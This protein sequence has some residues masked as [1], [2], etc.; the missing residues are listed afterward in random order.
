[1]NFMAY[2]LYL[3]HKKIIY[4]C[5]HTY[6][7]IHTYVYIRMHAYI[8]MYTYIFKQAPNVT[9][10][11]AEKSWG[12]MVWFPS[13]SASNVTL[14][15]PSDSLSMFLLFPMA[16]FLQPTISQAGG[17][18]I[19]I[20]FCLIHPVFPKLRTFPLPYFQGSPC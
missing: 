9:L 8:R 4:I 13:P 6:I 14:I 17:L 1:M 10:F 16:S 20:K 18:L 5:I 15:I 2:E 19:T 7:H 12:C 11:Q 3:T